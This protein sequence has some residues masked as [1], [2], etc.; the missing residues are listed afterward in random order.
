MAVSAR[1]PCQNWP[2]RNISDKTKAPPRRPLPPPVT[3]LRPTLSLSL[4][5]ALAAAAPAVVGLGVHAAVG[6]RPPYQ[7]LPTA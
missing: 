1:P 6:A 4:L 3:R 5:L 7:N 2:P